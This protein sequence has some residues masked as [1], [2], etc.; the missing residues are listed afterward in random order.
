MI[1]TEKEALAHAIRECALHGSEW[2]ILNSAQEVVWQIEADT[3]VDDDALVRPVIVHMREGTLA[4]E[5]I[6]I[7]LE[8]VT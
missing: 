8:V 4:T 6:A 2:Q 5:G 7:L 1:G 3:P